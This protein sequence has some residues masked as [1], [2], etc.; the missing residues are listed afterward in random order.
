MYVSHNKPRQAPGLPGLL[1]VV[2][3]L[4]QAGLAVSPRPAWKAHPAAFW[5]QLAHA[6]RTVSSRYWTAMHS[7]MLGIQI[8]TG[9]LQLGLAGN[10]DWYCGRSRLR[11]SRHWRRNSLRSRARRILR[12]ESVASAG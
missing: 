12:H 9:G 11:R 6:R 7:C 8:R 2:R 3:I 4:A 1:F 10:R 5:A